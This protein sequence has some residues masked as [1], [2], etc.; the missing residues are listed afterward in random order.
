MALRALVAPITKL[1]R[2]RMPAL[3][4]GEPIR[5]AQPV[6]VVQA[7]A[8]GPKPGVELAERTWIVPS[9]LRTGD[10]PILLR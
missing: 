5:P 10:P 1:P 3:R 8:V 4:A 2:S 7:V 6:Q 9:G